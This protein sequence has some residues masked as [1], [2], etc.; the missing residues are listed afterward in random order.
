MQTV[1]MKSEKSIKSDKENNGVNPQNFIEP[2][3]KRD[4]KERSEKAIDR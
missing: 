1:S 3:R 2:C 4:N